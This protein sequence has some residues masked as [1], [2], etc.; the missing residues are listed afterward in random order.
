M[1]N[2]CHNLRLWL[3]MPRPPGPASWGSS[4]RGSGEAC[5]WSG[6]DAMKIKKIINLFF[7]DSLLLENFSSDQS[8][9]GYG[10]I[11]NRRGGAR[12][13]VASY[14]SFTPRSAL[15][16]Q[17]CCFGMVLRCFKNRCRL[18]VGKAKI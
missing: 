10:V 12:A 1:K 4:R 2:F 9:R 7:V 14:A 15:K 13:S 5:P 17:K 16:R 6:K 11:K 8:L 3:A 18:G